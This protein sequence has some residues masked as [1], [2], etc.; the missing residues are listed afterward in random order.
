MIRSE[1]QESRPDLAI[2]RLPASSAMLQDLADYSVI[3][4]SY[5]SVERSLR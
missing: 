2:V 4:Q 3:W 5:A 1:H